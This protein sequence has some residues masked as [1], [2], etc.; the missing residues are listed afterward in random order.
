MEDK[1]SVD[2]TEMIAAHSSAGH[3]ARSHA[4]IAK[5]R[6]ECVVNLMGEVGI[7]PGFRRG[8]YNLGSITIVNEEQKKCRPM[9][10]DWETCTN[11]S[12]KLLHAV[13]RCFLGD[14][15]IVHM[16]FAQARR[17]DTNEPAFFGQFLQ[18]AL[19]PT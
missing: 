5:R 9:E 2:S 3:H 13:I 10:S 6:G 15:H 4:G 17:S 16:R 18:R 14:D 7:A 19:A 12:G 1:E 11:G 8:H